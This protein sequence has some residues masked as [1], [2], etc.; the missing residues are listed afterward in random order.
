MRHRMKLRHGPFMAIQS[1]QKDVEL[2]LNDEKRQAIA[3]G[4]TV[5]FTDAST[6]RTLCAQVVG[7]RVFPDFE[8][9]YARYDKIRIGYT[10][11]EVADPKD[12]EQYYTP[13]DIA[14]FGVVAIEIQVVE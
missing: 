1:G 11:D 12:M 4:D 5:E 10:A 2:R 9:L 3:V 8:A 6:G 14:C 7:K 13:A